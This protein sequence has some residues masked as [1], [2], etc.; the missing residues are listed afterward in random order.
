MIW[1]SHNENPITQ[2]A[3]ESLTKTAVL[4]ILKAH[5]YP[6]EHLVIDTSLSHHNPTHGQCKCY[7]PETIESTTHHKQ[8]LSPSIFL[9]KDKGNNRGNTPRTH[10]LS[11]LQLHSIVEL[12]VTIDLL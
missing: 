10:S 3:Q 12:G 4:A 7:E 2:L 11:L 6:N 9:N 1:M 5:Q 8:E